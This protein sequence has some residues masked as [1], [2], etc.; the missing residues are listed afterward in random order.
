MYQHPA[1][2]QTLMSVIHQ[3]TVK[4]QRAGMSLETIIATLGYMAD[5]L[6]A[7]L[8]YVEAERDKENNPC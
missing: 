8:P 5:R 7:A 2:N 6:Q 4:A 3:E 1:P